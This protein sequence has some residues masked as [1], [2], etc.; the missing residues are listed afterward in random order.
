V[1]SSARIKIAVGLAAVV[2]LVAAY[3]LLERSGLMATLMDGRAL[4]QTV[5]GLGAAG[6]LAVVGFM[7]L[8][9]LV[10]PIPSAPI[11]LAAGAAYGHTW[12]TVYILVGAELGALLAFGLARLLGRD[13]LQRWLGQRLP[14]TRLGSQ[15]SLM[16]IVFVSRL[17]PFVSFDVVSYAAGLTSLALW[18]F[19]LATLAGILPTS[20]LLA[21]FGG[22]MATGEIDRIMYSVLALG[23]LTAVPL[24]IH[25]LRRRAGR[26]EPPAQQGRR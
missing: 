11:A 14:H 26:D 19:A 22:E 13:V 7:T 6:P 1:S 23:L 20:F 3:W 4:R 8:A 18:R 10:S 16:T 25:L 15:G 17:L 9:I 12:G 2:A 5:V 21:H 24:A